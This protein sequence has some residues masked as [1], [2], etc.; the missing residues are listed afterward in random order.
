MRRFA[1]ALSLA[2]IPLPAAAIVNGAPAGG[3]IAAQTALIV[4]TRGASCSG[5]VLAPD[6][7]LTAAHCVAPRA[8]YAI[9]VVGRGA[10]QLIPVV[11][12]AL[13]PRFDP[14]QFKTR[15]PTPDLALLKLAQPLPAQFRAAQLARDPALPRPGDRFTLAG[16]GTIA[17]GDEKSAGTLRALTLPAIGTTGGI[18]VRLAGGGGACTGDSG[19][20]AFRDGLV[21]AVIGWTTGPTGRGCGHVTGATLVGLHIEWIEAAA[22][23]LG[24][25]LGN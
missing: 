19:G 25:A 6:L 9:A 24:S 1:L 4:S 21:A 12:I 11:R 17:E 7:V 8:S 15:R 18:M 2:L 23:E 10:S 13:H 22:R 16:F 14:A 3:E 20:P 5:A